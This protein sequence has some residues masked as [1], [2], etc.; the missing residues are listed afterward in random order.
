M[1]LSFLVGLTTVGLSRKEAAPPHLDRS[2]P[3]QIVWP[4]DIVVFDLD[5][6][7]APQDSYSWSA[8]F[9]QVSRLILGRFPVAFSFAENMLDFSLSGLALPGWHPN[10]AA[11]KYTARILTFPISLLYRSFYLLSHRA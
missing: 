1:P 2:L 8:A 5:S 4:S 7:C 9:R 11:A 6:R 3:L 10:Q